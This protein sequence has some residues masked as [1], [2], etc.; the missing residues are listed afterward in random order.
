[1]FG[2]LGVWTPDSQECGR[3]GKA[4]GER[5]AAGKL[6]RIELSTPS[7]LQR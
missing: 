3:G 1:M 7:L 5:T 6:S 4:G 2:A